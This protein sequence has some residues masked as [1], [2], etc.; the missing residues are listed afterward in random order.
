VASRAVLTLRSGAEATRQADESCSYSDPGLRSSGPINM[1]SS[2]GRLKI[3][4]RIMVVHDWE[5]RSLRLGQEVG[6]TIRS[7]TW[8]TAPRCRNRPFAAPQRRESS[9]IPA[10]QQARRWS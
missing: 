1:W 6:D 4:I 3:E 9:A 10:L 8:P 2:L 7:L 5:V